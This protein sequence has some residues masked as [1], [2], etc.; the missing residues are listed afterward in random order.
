[1]TTTKDSPAVQAIKTQNKGYLK[2][3]VELEAEIVHL[4]EALRKIAEAERMGYGTQ[5]TYGEMAQRA[6]N[7]Y[8]VAR[9]NG[10]KKDT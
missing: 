6:L 10:L 3:I 1:M 7:Q 5:R 2:T 4:R 8:E 9:D